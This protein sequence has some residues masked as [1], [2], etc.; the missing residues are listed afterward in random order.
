MTNL[1]HLDE[2]FEVSPKFAGA[3]ASEK[4]SH[5]PASLLV[6]FQSPGLQD[7]DIIHSSTA[8]FEGSVHDFLKWLP[9]KNFQI[10]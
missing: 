6:R 2:H 4:R 7:N 5:V 9:V 10:S 1:G 3:S 8:L